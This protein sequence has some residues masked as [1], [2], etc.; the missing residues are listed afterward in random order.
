M[1]NRPAVI[2]GLLAV[3]DTG[4]VANY[5]RAVEAQRDELHGLLV[6]ADSLLSLLW[7]RYVPADRRDPD[8]ERDVNGAIAALRRATKD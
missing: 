6:R 1:M 5:I 7:H 3:D 4:T 8:L 2:T